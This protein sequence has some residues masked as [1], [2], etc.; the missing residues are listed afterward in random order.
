MDAVITPS[1]GN[2]TWP[3][4]CEGLVGDDGGMIPRKIMYLSRRTAYEA[5]KPDAKVMA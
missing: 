4:K 1:D 3:E 2:P 5:A